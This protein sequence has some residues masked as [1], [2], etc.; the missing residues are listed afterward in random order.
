[1]QS[2][3]GDAEA[4]ELMDDTHYG[5]TAGVYTKDGEAAERILAGMH[6]K[7]VSQVSRFYRFLQQRTAA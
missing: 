2:V 3:S 7:S 4:V 6:G 1:M 5:L